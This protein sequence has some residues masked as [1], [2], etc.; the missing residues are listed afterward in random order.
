VEFRS[1][2]YFLAL[3]V[4]PDHTV[5]KRRLPCFCVSVFGTHGVHLDVFRVVDI[6]EFLVNVGTIRSG[7]VKL[8]IKLA[9][10]VSDLSGIC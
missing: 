6:N 9:R 2:P 5:H 7:K 4:P 1:I 3:R 10:L 8:R